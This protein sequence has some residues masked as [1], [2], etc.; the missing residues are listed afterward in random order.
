MLARR[1]SAIEEGERE[2][3]VACAYFSPFIKIQTSKSIMISR[4][5]FSVVLPFSTYN[6]IPKYQPSFVTTIARLIAFLVVRAQLYNSLLFPVRRVY[7]CKNSYR[8]PPRKAAVRNTR[9]NED[10]GAGTPVEIER[11]GREERGKQFAAFLR[12]RFES[13]RDPAAAAVALHHLRK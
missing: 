3:H 10:G 11:R 12:P 9:S 5:A 7:R 4:L 2:G 13:L 8:T 6:L 1:S